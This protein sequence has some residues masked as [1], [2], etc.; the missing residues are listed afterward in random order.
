MKNT[1]AEKSEDFAVRILNL[2]RYLCS[3]YREYDVFRQ[4]LRSGTSI[5]ANIAESE[6]AISKSDFLAKRYI[7]LKECSETLFWLRVLKRTDYLTEKQFN[8]IYM[9]CLELKRMLSA[10][11]KTLKEHVED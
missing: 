7:S 4:L 3:E 11:T 5:G 9:D 1:V 10:A 6:C 2:Y 8:S